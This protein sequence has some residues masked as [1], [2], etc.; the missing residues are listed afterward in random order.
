MALKLVTAPPVEPVTLDEVKASLRLTTADEDTLLTNFIIAA[1]M[2]CEFKTG[3]SLITTAWRL[4]LDS[5]DELREIPKPPL[6]SVTSVT[7]VDSNGTEQTLDPSAYRVDSDSEPGR[8]EPVDAQ[9][10][11]TKTQVNAVTVL[12][13]AG[14]G[15]AGS[16]VPMPVRQWIIL[17]VG[18]MYANRERSSTER[19]Q[20]LEFADGLLDGANLWP[21]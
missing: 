3:R 9:W 7:Y 18:D 13:T 1:R 6:Q 21:R 10:P 16:A 19:L 8:I 5:F 20:A 15:D 12:F 11:A 4:T 2:D 17:A 14:Y